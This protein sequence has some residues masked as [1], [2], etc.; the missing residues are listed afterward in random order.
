MATPLDHHCQH[1]DREQDSRQSDRKAT[2]NYASCHPILSVVFDFDVI[3]IC[4]VD[5]PSCCRDC[6]LNE[7]FKAF[8]DFARTE[9]LSRNPWNLTR[10]L[11]PN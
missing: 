7:A 2:A 10:V 4:H 8:W 9:F 1:N 3:L 11:Y 6:A 5:A